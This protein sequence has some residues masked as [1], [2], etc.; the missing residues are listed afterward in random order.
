MNTESR[1]TEKVP[2]PGDDREVIAYFLGELPAERQSRLED[3]CFDS[4]EFAAFVTAVESELIDEYARGGLTAIER[5]H[6]ERNYL[7]NDQR[8]A[9][10]EFAVYLR[11]QFAPDYL[12]QRESGRRWLRS[13]FTPAVLKW[14]TAFASILLGWWAI[15]TMLGQRTRAPKDEVITQ[16]TQKQTTEPT[17]S[18]TTAPSPR[19][20]PNVVTGRVIAAITL[21]AGS[22]RDNSR[23]TP[24]LKLS[25][26]TTAADFRL[27]LEGE[28]YTR[29]RAELQTR[30]GRAIWREGKLKP[31]TNAG[32]QREILVR[33]P[34][35]K[36][37]DGDY[38]LYLYG[39]DKDGESA[40]NDYSFR[41]IRD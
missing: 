17:P 25:S 8:I 14:A 40:P 7:V 1:L 6:F 3:A 35:G 21:T 24:V 13:F 4:E 20:S 23:P 34:A 9:R 33:A 12:P 22:S 29:Y 41:V 30:D 16:V 38:V 36:L 11:R 32:S 26:I 2:L 28:T 31:Q 27:I 18:A 19:P 15:S 39:I 37:A 10:V 5:Q